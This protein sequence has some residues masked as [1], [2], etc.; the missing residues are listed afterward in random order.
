MT[1]ITLTHN[2]YI[3]NFANSPSIIVMNLYLLS[4]QKAP[5]ITVTMLTHYKCLENFTPE[6]NIYR[7]DCVYVLGSSL[8][9]GTLF[10]SFAPSYSYWWP[11]SWERGAHSVPRPHWLARSLVKTCQ[12]ERCSPSPSS[13]M[14][15]APRSLAHWCH[16]ALNIVSFGYLFSHDTSY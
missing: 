1:S 3:D 11:N 14:L 13:L 5:F 12:G 8:R 7:V 2:I 9:M 16:A 6:P 10:P 15:I 4:I